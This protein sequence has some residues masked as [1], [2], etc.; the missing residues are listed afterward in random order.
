MYFQLQTNGWT[1]SLVISSI[2]WAIPVSFHVTDSSNPFLAYV[3]FIGARSYLVYASLDIFEAIVFRLIVELI[4]KRVPPVNED[5]FQVFLGVLNL[6]I[7]ILTVLQSFFTD[8]VKVAAMFK[9]FGASKSLDFNDDNPI[10]K[11]YDA[12]VYVAIIGIAFCGLIHLIMLSCKYI[13]WLRGQLQI[14]V[15]P[16]AES[17]VIALNNQARNKELI[18]AKI[19]AIMV[20]IAITT[21][22]A[23]PNVITR[24]FMDPDRK[25]TSKE[26]FLIDTWKFLCITIFLPSWL[27]YQNKYLRKFAMAELLKLV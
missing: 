13:L 15:S 9:R 25:L 6:L 4:W 19:Q 20:V 10:I 23:T 16:V 2:I 3:A 14:K 12:I 17:S 27:Y 11:L 21:S 8:P 7:S 26:E 5:F 24:I 1:F 22:L 18:T